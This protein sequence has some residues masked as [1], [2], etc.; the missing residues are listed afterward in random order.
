MAVRAQARERMPLSKEPV[1]VTDHWAQRQKKAHSVEGQT[2]EP[3]CGPVAGCAVWPAILALS[4]AIIPVPVER[5]F[6]CISEEDEEGAGSS[7]PPP[8]L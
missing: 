1:D 3:C 5:F 8:L 2:F 7:L 4:E 6:S